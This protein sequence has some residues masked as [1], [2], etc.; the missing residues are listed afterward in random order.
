MSYFED[1]KNHLNF[2]IRYHKNLIKLLLEAQDITERYIGRFNDFNPVES[3]SKLQRIFILFS[4]HYK[5]T[6][7]QNIFLT[8]IIYLTE[9]IWHLMN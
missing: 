1:E 8:K 3:V 2:P 4:T 6:Y 5:L 7:L 9:M